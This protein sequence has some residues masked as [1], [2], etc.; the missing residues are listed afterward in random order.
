MNFLLHCGGEVFLGGF[1]YVFFAVLS[2]LK[3]RILYS[4][5]FFLTNTNTTP[6]L[7]TVCVSMCSPCMVLYLQKVKLLRKNV[8]S[9]VGI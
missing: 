8:D 3:K 5:A 2:E 7:C 9:K 6:Y 1:F 4:A